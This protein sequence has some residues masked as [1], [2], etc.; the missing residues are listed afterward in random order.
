MWSP[1]LLSAIM[2]LDCF[3]ATEWFLSKVL[4]HLSQLS[5]YNSLVQV[6][7]TDISF[8]I[9]WGKMKSTKYQPFTV[10][11]N[12]RN[13]RYTIKLKFSLFQLNEL[14]ENNLDGVVKARFLFHK[15]RFCQNRTALTWTNG[16]LRNKENA[17][18]L[19]I[20]N[21][22]ASGTIFSQRVT[23]LIFL[24]SASP[25]MIDWISSFQTQ[26]FP[27]TSEVYWR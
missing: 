17:W 10:F 19:V 25:D 12:F 7:Q 26:L 24:Y 14:Y 16:I 11:C 23:N 8:I 20:I 21:N 15:A 5:R 4:I 9:T 18:L 13:L 27:T 3:L 22:S 2:L 6:E 1:N